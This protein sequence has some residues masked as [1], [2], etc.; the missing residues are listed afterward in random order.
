MSD[1][2]R[3]I[4]VAVLGGGCGAMA[5][6]F[7]L[8]ATPELREKYE[9]TVYQ[10][11]WRLGGKGASGRNAEYGQRIEEHGLHMWMGFYENAFSVIRRCYD[12]WDKAPNNPFKT[13]EQAFTPQ[14]QISLQEKIEKDGAV[15][16]V[17]WNI[18]TPTLPG[19]PGDGSRTSLL[20][21]SKAMLKW[22]LSRHEEGDHTGHGTK[23]HGALHA[24]GK[25]LHALEEG[26]HSHEHLKPVRD[27]IQDGHS[28]AL[29]D[30]G[31]GESLGDDLRRLRLMIHLGWAVFKGFIEDILPHGFEGFQR[32]NHLEFKDWLKSHGAKQDVVD[33]API[34]ALYDL[35]FAYRDGDQDKPEAA[36][37]VALYVLLNIMFRCKKAVLFKMNAGMGDTIFTPL[38]EVLLQRGVQFKFFHRVENLGLSPDKNLIEAIELTEQVEVA[39]PGT[40]PLTNYDPL[41]PVPVNHG[42]EAIPCWPSEP[43]WK[44]IENGPAIKAALEKERL[45]LENWWCQ[46]KVGSKTLKLG[47][48][49]DLVVM[50]IS[51]AGLKST[52]PELIDADSRFGEM[53]ENLG[54]VQTQAAQLWLKPNLEGL[55]WDHGTTVMTTYADPLNTWGEMSHLLPFED[56]PEEPGPGSVEYF[57]GPLADQETAPCLE[58]SSP[59]A[60]ATDQAKA[61]AIAWMEQHIGHLWPE[62]TDANGVGLNWEKLYD[63][64]GA[65]GIDRF[66]SQYWRA[67][68]DPSERY[69]LS[70]PDTIRYRLDSGDSGF[71][72][73]YLAG[74]WVRTRMNS[75]CVEGAVGGG[76]RA[77]RAISGFPKT[78]W[79]EDDIL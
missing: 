5:A 50:G 12:E 79:G 35:G 71:E 65:N 17:T 45:I 47:A 39:N 69:V 1:S 9:L 74:D 29:A 3:K 55:G 18:P 56:W 78:I 31:Q 72:N 20:D 8:T 10:Q 49:F 23:G 30:A 33:S 77:A 22:L 66:D 37:G 24:I 60:C 6:A 75:G 25:V 42:P 70:L 34:R 57:C 38:Y 28:H 44:D 41:V 13:W 21:L 73:L 62:A 4:R 2:K 61:T 7:E 32:I 52:C 54:T 19:E 48:D 76:M 40:N 16:W 14:N 27:A 68:I 46:Q 63:P 67:N 59:P 36:A 51:V 43:K 53:V 26:L 15:E 11:G 64:R 58:D